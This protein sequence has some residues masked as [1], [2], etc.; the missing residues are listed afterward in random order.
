VGV[1]DSSTFNKLNILDKETS[2]R[3]FTLFLFD[4]ALL[5]LGFSPKNKGPLKENLRYSLPP[6]RSL[7]PGKEKSFLFFGTIYLRRKKIM[8]FLK[9][10]LVGAGIITLNGCCVLGMFIKF[11]NSSQPSSMAAT[12]V[13]ESKTVT[14]KDMNQQAQALANVGETTQTKEGIKVNLKGDLSFAKGSADLNPAAMDS[15]SK[16][17]DQLNKYPQETVTV[18]G[19]TDNRGSK[20]DNLFLSKRRAQVVKAQLVKDGVSADRISAFGMGD[21]DPVA[22]ND[23]PENR[24]KNR[25]TEILIQPGK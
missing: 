18:T 16:I 19:Y 2:I 3:S 23:T 17:A 10:V 24:A 20:G 13:A 11:N 14:S 1:D 15:L 9:F 6:S 21:K 25:R 7:N 22:P 5:L 12:P 8:R 4:F